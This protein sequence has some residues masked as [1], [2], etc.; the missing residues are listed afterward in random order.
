[1]LLAAEEAAKGRHLTAKGVQKAFGFKGNDKLSRLSYQVKTL[2]QL[3]ALECVG[4]EQIRGAYQKHYVPS[5]AF[6]ATM[7]DTVALDQIAELI[8][9]A[10]GPGFSQ[11][12]RAKLVQIV[13]AAGRPVEA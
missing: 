13:Q 2:W 12:L 8:D 4:G 6:Q 3:G 7:T 1:M 5:K 9:N 11:A 10:S